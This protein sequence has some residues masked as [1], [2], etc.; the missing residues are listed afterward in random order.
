MKKNPLISVIIPNYNY[1][2]YLKEAINSVQS[3]T[4]SN[5]EIIV[6]NNGSTDDS[7]NLLNQF[8][9]QIK[10]IDQENLGQAEARNSGLRAAKGELLAFLDADDTWQVDKL[11]KQIQL[12]TSKCELVYSGIAQFRNQTFELEAVLLPKFGGDCHKYF[13]NLAAVSIVL[14][15]ESTCLFTRNLLNRAGYFDPEL[16]SASGWDF[17]RRC[18]K[19]TTFNFVNEPLTNYRIHENNM[20]KSSLNNIKDIRKAYG[21]IFVDEDLSLSSFEKQKIISRLEFSFVK[22]YLKEKNLLLTL[23]TIFQSRQERNYI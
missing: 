4:Y 1:A 15:G 16:N 6:V 8:G 13:V 9:E 22:T 14:S 18:S 10:L 20:S 23:N 3:Q 17:F 5:T 7:L 2:R 21:R 12:I 11:E 19:F